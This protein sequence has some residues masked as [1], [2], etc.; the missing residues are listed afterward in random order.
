MLMMD[1]DDGYLK[2]LIWLMILG[3]SQ[4]EALLERVFMSVLW[5][6]FSHSHTL[7]G[8]VELYPKSLIVLHF[9]WRTFRVKGWGGLAGS[10]NPEMLSWKTL[11]GMGPETQMNREEWL[12]E[13]PFDL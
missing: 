7:A 3:V 13:S 10:A 1:M 12:E 9:V 11:V 4:H 6:F 2:S 8:P 5:F